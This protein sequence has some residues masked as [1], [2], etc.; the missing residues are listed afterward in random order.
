MEYSTPRRTPDS[1]SMEQSD[2]I[3]QDYSVALTWFC[4]TRNYTLSRF[5]V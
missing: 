5:S 1:Y 2:K 3:I 4:L